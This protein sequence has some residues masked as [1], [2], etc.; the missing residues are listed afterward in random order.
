MPF[1]WLLVGMAAAGGLTNLIEDGGAE[2]IT[3][4]DL[5]AAGYTKPDYT[6]IKGNVLRYIENAKKHALRRANA[7]ARRL[8]YDTVAKNYS[9]TEALDVEGMKKMAEI[10]AQQESEDRQIRNQL[11]LKNAEINAMPEENPISRFIGGAI[12]GGAVGASLM[13]ALSSIEL[14]NAFANNL[15]GG[16]NT[17]DKIVDVTKNV[18]SVI[19]N[20]T[21]KAANSKIQ[22][23]MVEGK[24]RPMG[25]LSDPIAKIANPINSLYGTIS[26]NTGIDKKDQPYNLTTLLPFDDNIQM[27]Q[28]VSPAMAMYGMY[29]RRKRR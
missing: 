19:P 17:L 7:E 24:L 15:Q 26:P 2:N 10:E 12:Q 8:G 27:G 22:L 20:L 23:E 6:K 11:A 25:S 13:S 29:K 9:A 21:G 4:E 16:T 14:N 3:Y 1:P 18:S 5:E 28:G